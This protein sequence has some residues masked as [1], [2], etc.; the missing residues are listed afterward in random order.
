MCFLS[1]FSGFLS[2]L[3]D[4]IRP[5]V[6]EG[7]PSVSRGGDTPWCELFKTIQRVDPFNY[8]NSPLVRGKEFSDSIYRTFEHFP[9]TKEYTD[10]GWL[11]LASLDKLEWEKDKLQNRISDLTA[12]QCVLKENLVSCSRRTEIAENQTQALI[13]RLA[14]LQ[15][16]MHSQPRKVSVVKVRALIGKP[17]DPE[18]WNG[19]IWEDSE[20]AGDIESE[21]SEGL[22]LP[23]DEDSPPSTE[24]ASPP[25]PGGNIPALPRTTVQGNADTLQDPPTPP[26]PPTFASRPITRS[27]SKRAPRGEVQIVTHEEERYTH[28]ELI[29]ISNSYKQRSGEYVWEWIL[30]VWDN[31]GNNI[32]LDQAEFID[33]G[34]LCRDSKFNTSARN[35]PKGTNSLFGW[36]AEVWTKRWLTVNDLE[37]P[38]LPWFSVD[39]GIQRLRELGMLEWICR[40]RPSPPQWTRPEDVPFSRT[41]RNKFV[42][43]APSSLKGPAVAILCMPELTVGDAIDQL[44]DLSAMGIIGSR[45][46][47]GQVAALNRQRQGSRAYHNGQQRR[48]DEQKGLTR[49]DLWH[50]LISHGVPRSQIDRKPTKFL[51]DLYKQKNSRTNTPKSDLNQ[52]SRE[53]RPLNQFPDLSQFTDPEPLD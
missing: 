33:M 45:S 19:D 46:N 6:S 21:H 30:R 5:K 27:K 7:R 32:Q 48:R 16:K 51:L 37:M 31:G 11:L 23:E 2:W 41:L 44:L 42:R 10:V 25:S 8:P 52:K 49:A 17:W 47:R 43:G 22:I 20:E 18:K 24:L 28:K 3:S 53:S 1:W 35:I 38:D 39:E 50:W 40:L 26:T 29:E 36:L 15:R 4:L 12:S 34:P 9:N 13:L 14:D